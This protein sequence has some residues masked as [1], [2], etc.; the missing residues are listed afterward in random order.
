MKKFVFVSMALLSGAAC[1]QSQAPTF[2]L[3]PG[4]ENFEQKSEIDNRIDVLWVIDN[5]GSM[6]NLQ[7][8]IAAN[9]QSFIQNFVQQGYDFQIAVTTTDAWR[10][11]FTG[12]PSRAEFRDGAGGNH[13]GVRVIV[14][15][16]PDLVDVFITN[17]TQGISGNGDERPFQSF[18]EALNSP[19]NAG[20][21]RQ[22]AYLAV[23]IV[24]DEEDFSHDTAAYSGENYDF[25]GLHTVASYKTYLDELTGSTDE[26]RYYSVSGIAIQ[27]ADCLAANQPDGNIADR[28]NQLVD[29]TGGLRGDVCS[30]DFAATL[31]EF[32][33]HIA[34]LS[35]QFRIERE[36][37]PETIRV[38]VDGVEVSPSSTNGW[39]YHSDTKTVRFHGASLPPQG[40]QISVHYEPVTIK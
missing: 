12:N 11:P 29:L 2:A 27:D 19:L 15:G 32:Q 3:L 5:S 40:A 35:T 36:L 22:G 37:H 30:S 14:P 8:N 4:E 31:D 20:F 38:F 21:L 26:L 24:T 6:A 1:T 25:P 9:F 28:V 39:T 17:I 18:K 13:S 16:T 23:I 7:N 10:A 34:E 33:N